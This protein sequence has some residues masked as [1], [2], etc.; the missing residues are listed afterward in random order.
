[1]DNGNFNQMNQ[2]NGMYNGYVDPT[3]DSRCT[4]TLIISI[5]QMLCC[6]QITGIIAL[7]Y[8]IMAKSL[9]KTSPYESEEKLKVAKTALKIGWILAII[10]FVVGILW[11]LVVIVWGGFNAALN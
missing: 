5:V 11:G 3:L 9:C 1:M 4:K 6:S 10:A 2:N 8:A 7:I